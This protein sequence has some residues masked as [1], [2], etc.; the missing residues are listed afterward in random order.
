LGTEGEAPSEAPPVGLR[1][2][3]VEYEGER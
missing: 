1:R 3:T 2:E